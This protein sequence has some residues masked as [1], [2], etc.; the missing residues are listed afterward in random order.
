MAD[1]QVGKIKGKRCYIWNCMDTETITALKDTTVASGSE[2]KP[3]RGVGSDEGIDKHSNNYRT[4][5]NFLRPHMGLDGETPHK[6]QDS[7]L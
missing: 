4:Y 6:W 3:G 2:T 7:T 1:E 5:Y